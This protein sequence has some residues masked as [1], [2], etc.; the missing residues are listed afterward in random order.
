MS[1]SERIS[2]AGLNALS[3]GDALCLVYLRNEVRAYC[4]PCAEH[5]S[6]SQSEAGAGAAVAYCGTVSRFLDVGNVVHQSVFFGTEYNLQRLLT[7]NASCSAGAYVMLR[8]LAHLH[9]HFVGKMTAAVIYARSR[10]TAGAGRHGE[11]VVLIKII[12]QPLVVADT[13]NVLDCALDGDNSHQSVAVR[14]D[15]SHELHTDPCV[16]LEGSADFGVLTHKLLIVDHHLKDAGGE[17]LHK[18]DVLAELLVK[19]PAEDAVVHQSVERRCDLLHG[20]AH[21]LC[22]VLRRALLAKSRCNGDVRLVVGDDVCHAVVFGGFLGYPDH[23]TRRTAD[24]LC[25][26]DYLGS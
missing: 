13:G 12:R 1:Q 10:R 26:F 16:L 9:A 24:D 25:Q 21:L 5:E 23:C 11:G 17:D 22:K 3:A 20:L 19:G 7:G 18:V 8:S 2:G 6:R 4:V 15:G 14:E